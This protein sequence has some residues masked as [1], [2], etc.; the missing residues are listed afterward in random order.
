MKVVTISSWL[1]FGGPAPPER[2]SAARRNFLAPPYYS[3]RAVFASLWAL[4]SF[5]MF[6]DSTILWTCL[7]DILPVEAIVFRNLN[8]SASM[9]HPWLH[10][11]AH[12]IIVSHCLFDFLSVLW[13]CWLGDRKG[14]RLVK[15]WVLVCGWWQFD[16]NFAG[17]IAPDVT[18]ISSIILNSNNSRWRFGVAVTRWS[19]STQLL[20]IEP[21]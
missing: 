7:C 21:G 1:N 13:H 5:L 9:W 12:V 10:Q 4:F 8:C 17:L 19:W 18:P 2:G 14:I 20:Y 3:R 6:L 11:A 15:S 16:W